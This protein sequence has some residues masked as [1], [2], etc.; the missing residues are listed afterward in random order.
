[1]V[2][3]HVRLTSGL[4]CLS[5]R[6]ATLMQDGTFNASLLA[7][8]ASGSDLHEVS[9]DFWQVL[10]Y[11]V[12]GKC[13]NSRRDGLFS[14]RECAHAPCVRARAH[15]QVYTPACTHTSLSRSLL[16]SHIHLL[17]LL[18][19][20]THTNTH[21][22]ARTH[23]NT[24]TNKFAQVFSSLP[25]AYVDSHHVDERSFPKIQIQI[26]LDFP[27]FFGDNFEFFSIPSEDFKCISHT[28]QMIENAIMLS[29]ALKTFQTLVKYCLKFKAQF[30]PHTMARSGSARISTGNGAA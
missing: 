27:S 9:T 20:Y 10:H 22:H 12:H 13:S 25:Q 7:G 4:R 26:I 19:F 17:N 2:C 15:A 23:A 29:K 5:L 21:P 24:Q 6:A 30:T 8:T 28:I 3:R 16:L 18:C 11:T 1:M 14:L